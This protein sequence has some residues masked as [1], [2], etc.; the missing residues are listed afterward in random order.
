MRP[1]KLKPTIHLSTEPTVVTSN[2][3]ISLRLIQNV[4]LIWL[5]RDIDEDNADFRNSLTQLRRVV[6]T[7]KTYTDP[8]QCVQFLQTIKNDKVCII[9]SGSLGEHIV[10]QLHDITQVD[11]VFVFCANEQRHKQW[12]NKWPKINGVFTDMKLICEALQ[13]TV[14]NCEQDAVPMSFIVP[15]D[16]LSKKPLDQLEP[17]FMYSQILKE[18]LLTIKFEQKHFRQFIQYYHKV[19]SDNN[20]ELKI[21][22]ELNIAKYIEEHYT[23]QSPIWWYTYPCFLYTMLNRALRLM[24]ADT[25][26]HLGFFISDLHRH[27]EKLHREQFPTHH[28]DVPFIV[29]RGQGLS[30]A[31]F[32]QLSQSKDGLLSFNNFLS[33]SKNRQTSLKF[34]HGAMRKPDMVGILFVMTIE[35]SKSTTSFAS[36]IKD[37]YFK[38]RE[39]EVLFSMHTVFRIQDITMMGVTDRLFEVKLSLTSDDDQELRK[40]TNRVREETS[41]PGKGWFRMGFLLLKMGQSSKAKEIYE[42][43]LEQSSDPNERGQIYNKIG[44]VYS[45]MG[46]YAKALSCNEKHLEISK[47]SLPSNHH[48]LGTSYNNIGGVYFSMGDYAKALSSYEKALVIY[49]Q[50]LP[51]NH[52]N[53]AISYNNI[54]LVYKHM[55]YYAKALSSYEKALAINQQ[56]LP[57]NH[58]D[59][60][61]SYNNIGGVYFSMGDYAKALSSYEKALVIYQQSLPP[62]HPD[63]AISYNNIG[64]VYKHMG[65]YAKALSSYEKALAINQQSLPPNHPDL[66]TSYNNI[67]GVYFSMGDYAKALSFYE[68]ALAIQKRSVPPNHPDLAI[69]YN[70]I[71]LVYSNM[72][73]YAKALSFY[74]KAL[75]IQK[76]SLPPNHPLLAISYNNIGLVYYNMGDYAK[77]L[78]SYEKT[79][80]IRQQ[81]L[82]PN[83]PDLATSYNNIGLVYK[84]MGDYAKALSFYEHEVRILQQTLSPNH[85]HLQTCRRNL[86][87]LKKK[88]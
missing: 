29:Y 64:L 42:I 43:L 40:L 87:I 5:D 1:N 55:G 71:G 51:P 28:S 2:Q 88:L 59:L 25:I 72:G 47:Q 48:D 80:A 27:I 33:T 61:T 82:P 14:Q 6:Y 60:A 13:K 15:S 83:H 68:K 41:A 38:E 65:Y 54:G 37:S 12:A 3:R 26:I 30:A 31:Q 77:A 62:N 73:D 86:E 21:A 24:D 20:K 49:Q 10:P 11:T 50:S 53:L 66:A 22:K 46:D 74:E 58:P 79:L 57:P 19:L 75:A 67:G 18:I 9:V 52:P 23:E 45:M 16:D 7:I 8:D 32:Q 4:L 78:S 84:H 36:I 35:P 56:S 85:P 76:R 69:S 34:A 44:L 39:D 63:L 70:N 81:S 17:S